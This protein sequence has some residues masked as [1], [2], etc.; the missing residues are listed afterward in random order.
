MSTTEMIT[1]TVYLDASATGIPARLHLK[2][3]GSSGAIRFIIVNDE[4][5]SGLNYKRAV[6]MGKLP[7]GTD[8]FVTAYTSMY[9]HKV[10]LNL[11]N[12]QVRN[13]TQH[14]GQ[15]RLTVSILNTTLQVRRSNY[16]EYDMLTVLP[17]YVTV[18][19]NA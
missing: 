17:L 7:D 4:G 18:H 9:D 8:Y 10:T 14:E 13:L 15:F 3:R 5:L 6:I 11:Y 19:G 12:S 1:H 2:K 16:L